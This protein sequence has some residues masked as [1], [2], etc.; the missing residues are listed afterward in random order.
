[1]DAAEQL[2]P[3]ETEPLSWAEICT[4][5]PEQFVCLVDIVPLELRSPE[6]LTARVVGAGGTRRAAFDPIR[7]TRHY[8]HWSVRFTGE[9]IKPLRRPK[10]IIDGLLGMN[11]LRHFNFEVRLTEHTILVELIEA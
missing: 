8:S 2:A 9:C 7:D 3:R 5:Y 11:F 4:R 10:S 6:I 1:M